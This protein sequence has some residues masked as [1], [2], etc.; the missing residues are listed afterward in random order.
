M[1]KPLVDAGHKMHT[2]FHKRRGPADELKAMG[3]ETVSTPRDVAKAADVIITILSFFESA[4]SCM[5]R[6]RS[7]TSALSCGSSFS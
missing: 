7:A 2:T 1:A 6:S 5:G 3:A 4:R